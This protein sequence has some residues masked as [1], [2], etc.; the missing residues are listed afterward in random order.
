MPSRLQCSFPICKLPTLLEPHDAWNHDDGRQTIRLMLVPDLN[1]LS[2]VQTP[3]MLAEPASTHGWNGTLC[4]M[5]TL[6]SPWLVAPLTPQ[7]P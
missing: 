6:P 7:Y 1:H 5:T 2:L 3:A 4:L